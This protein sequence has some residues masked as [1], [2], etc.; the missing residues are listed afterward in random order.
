MS[1]YPLS[2]QMTAFVEKTVSFNSTDNSLGGLRQAY[3][4]MCR[5]F[6]PSRPAGLYV[7]DFELAGVSVR[8]YQPPVSPPTSGP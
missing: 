2:E 7:V 6:T 1:S 8:S 5:A 4:D 3:S